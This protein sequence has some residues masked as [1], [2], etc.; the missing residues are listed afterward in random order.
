MMLDNTD[1]RESN[2]ALA[3][4]S[5]VRSIATAIAPAIM[6]AFLAHAG[7]NVQ[8]NV[9]AV[10]PTQ[11]TVPPLKNAAELT[12][13]F[14]AL[15]ADPALADK[16]KNVVFPDYSAPQTVK[17]DMS[18][19]GTG[20]LSPDLVELLQSSD[21][22]NITDRSKTLADKFFALMTPNQVRIIQA[23][24]QEGI[25]ALHFQT[26]DLITAIDGFRTAVAVAESAYNASGNPAL[27]AQ[28]E[29]MKTQLAGLQA[30]NADIN[31]AI[32]QLTELQE[33]VPNAFNNAKLDYLAQIEGKR[34]E[35]E[36]AFQ[37]TLNGGFKNVYLTTAISSFLALIL[38]MFYRNRQKEELI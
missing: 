2:S 27:L 22:T 21:V 13:E 1:P 18:S 14:N 35:I 20:T 17:I 25:N 12:A 24:V 30:A 4:L 32:V 6:V 28:L 23:G 34:S 29:A 38:L 36:A 7:A 37:S 8:T 33:D 3:T 9:M 5:L 11:I 10:L 16:L 26:T 15:K 31:N 19:S